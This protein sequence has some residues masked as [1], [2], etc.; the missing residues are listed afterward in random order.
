MDSSFIGLQGLATAD[1]MGLFDKVK[2]TVECPECGLEV[3]REIQ[4]K[5]PGHRMETYEIGD[6]VQGVPAGRPLLKTRFVCAGR[7]PETSGTHEGRESGE[8]E[9]G[10]PADAEGGEGLGEHRV[11]CWIHFDRGFL[12]DVTANKPERPAQRE[13]WMIEQAGWNAQELARKVRGLGALV[14]HRR[15][16]IEAER[17]G[18]LPPEGEAEPLLGMHRLRSEAELL[19]RL[20]SRLENVEE[21][22]WPRS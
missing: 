15:E 10:M 13:P 20:E 6:F 14:R 19:D 9:A 4:F 3:P 12:T 21:R 18:K 7:E 17:T 11:E 8:A 2:A 5:H 16:T 1:A 22:L